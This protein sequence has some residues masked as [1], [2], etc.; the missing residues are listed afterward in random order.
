MAS[1]LEG[2]TLLTVGFSIVLFSKQF[3]LSTWSI[4]ALSASLT[5]SFALGAIIGGRLGDLFGRRVVYSA[6]LIVYACGALICA[7][8]QNQAMFFAGVITIGLAMG[9]DLPASRDARRERTGQYEAA[10]HRRPHSSHRTLLG[11]A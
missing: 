3:N 1:Y 2:A 5:T 10:G 11:L 6:D 7:L 8:S 9:A 4:G